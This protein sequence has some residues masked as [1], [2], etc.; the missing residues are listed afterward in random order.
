VGLRCRNPLMHLSQL[1]TRAIPL[2]C[3]Q[4]GQEL[5]RPWYIFHGIF[6][7]T[8]STICFQIFKGIARVFNWR[9]WL[10]GIIHLKPTT[11]CQIST[12]IFE[13]K[14]K[15]ART[16]PSLIYFSW[17]IYRD[18]LHNFFSNI[19]VDIWHPTVGL[20]CIIVPRHSMK[21]ISKTAKFLP[22]L[23]LS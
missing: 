12:L 17:D 13:K 14:S 16:L 15:W 9:K 4:S 20:R 8:P 22:T 18:P 21:N 5:C 10:G 7:E 23:G 19:N 1:K 2:I 6:I 3:S 11:G